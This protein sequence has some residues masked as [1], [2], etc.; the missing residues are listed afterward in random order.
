[1]ARVAPEDVQQAFV[2]A[3]KAN[4][5]LSAALP[6]GLWGW[7]ASAPATMP[8]AAIKVT[9]LGTP[10]QTTGSPYVKKFG[11]N[12]EARAEAGGA[13]PNTPAATENIRT[14]LEGMVGSNDT[15]STLSVPNAI[16]VISAFPRDGKSE[17][18]SERKDTQTVL[19]TAAAWE[20][21]VQGS[22]A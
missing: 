2:A 22:R 6:G 15:G 16:K 12:I 17:V 9:E 13:A 18:D 5:S 11:V 1:M 4:A 8:Y 7:Q 14:L 19:V 3:F 10:V 20:L 21:W